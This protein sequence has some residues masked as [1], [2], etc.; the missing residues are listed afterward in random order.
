MIV[1][2]KFP[3]LYYGLWFSVESFREAHDNNADFVFFISN[4]RSFSVEHVDY[5]VFF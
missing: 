2:Y 1:D 4:F 3:I 5:Y